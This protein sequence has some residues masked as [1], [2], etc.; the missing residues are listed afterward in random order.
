VRSL[1]LLNFLPGTRTVRCMLPAIGITKDYARR[2]KLPAEIQ[3]HFYVQNVHWNVFLPFLC[4]RYY[5]CNFSFQFNSYPPPFPTPPSFWTCF[6]TPIHPHLS[7]IPLPKYF[8]VRWRRFTGETLR[9][10]SVWDSPRTSWLSA[11]CDPVHT[12]QCHMS[13]LWVPF[14]YQVVIAHFSVLHTCSCTDKS[15][16]SALSASLRFLCGFRGQKYSFNT[17]QH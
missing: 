3:L 6:S 4:K 2:T 1:V 10:V 17:V 15:L 7:L 5:T 11:V 13:T 14:R 8:F 9:L 16:P 12:R